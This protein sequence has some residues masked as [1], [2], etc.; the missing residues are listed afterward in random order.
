MNII[1]QTARLSA[2]AFLALILS[3]GSAS[4]TFASTTTHLSKNWSG[5][6]MKTGAFTAVSATWTVASSTPTN[7]RLSAE[8][9]WVGIGGTETDD[10]IQAGTQVIFVSGKPQYMAW[11]ETL[12]DAQRQLPVAIK[13]GDIVSV[14]L[15][16]TKNNVWHL[17]F[18]NRTTSKAYDTNITYTSSHS[19]VEWI[20]ERPLAVT[21]DGTGYLPLNNFGTINFTNATARVNGKTVNMD[22]QNSE[23][24]VMSSTGVFAEALPVQAWQGSFS[25]IYLSR[26]DGRAYLRSLASSYHQIATS[27]PQQKNQQPVQNLDPGNGTYIVHIS[28]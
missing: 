22:D 12:P 27:T 7:K 16:E 28:F 26:A 3:V 19:S 24:V 8:A 2:Y 23:Q 21:G 17:S 14:S 18:V 9:A 5:Y 11:Y 25:V 4:P 1:S 20:V 6:E 10:L 15:A 13:P